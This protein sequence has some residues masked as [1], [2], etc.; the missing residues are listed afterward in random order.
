MVSRGCITG[1]RA[2]D[3]TPSERCPDPTT[4]STT[5]TRQARDK[6]ASRCPSRSGPTTRTQRGSGYRVTYKSASA[7]RTDSPSDE[8]DR[9]TPRARSTAWVNA[10]GRRS[11]PRRF[12]ATCGHRPRLGIRA[13]AAAPADPAA[14]IA[15]PPS[16]YENVGARR[17]CSRKTPLAELDQHS[18]YLNRVPAGRTGGRGVPAEAARGA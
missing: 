7:T 6:R 2:S 10:R 8:T 18:A 11:A 3:G 17:F 16:G 14:I 13:S 1:V 5:A 15:T 9:P 12:R 4:V